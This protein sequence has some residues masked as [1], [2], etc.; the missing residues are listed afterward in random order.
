M[1]SP[2]M[3][4]NDW[5]ACPTPPIECPA[6][7]N[8]DGQVNVDDLLIV[9]NSWGVCA[10]LSFNNQSMMQGTASPAETL[11]ELLQSIPEVP[12]EIIESV[13]AIVNNEQ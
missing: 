3:V 9:I 10:N 7:A 1:D 12:Q 8:L 11:L 4:I 6:D 5:G 2:L 13:E